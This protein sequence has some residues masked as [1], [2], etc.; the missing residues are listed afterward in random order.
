MKVFS[1]FNDFMD[2]IMNDSTIMSRE[3]IKTA[4]K[5]YKLDSK[6]AHSLHDL[7]FSKFPEIV[8]NECLILE[9]RDSIF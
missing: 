4:E 2:L 8:S 6:Y 7:I 5:V 9:E 3:I 1:N